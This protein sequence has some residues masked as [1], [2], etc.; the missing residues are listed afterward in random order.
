MLPVGSTSSAN[1]KSALLG[2]LDTQDVMID[3]KRDHSQTYG[4]ILTYSQGSLV[5]Y[6]GAYPSLS[7]EEI[8]LANYREAT[9]ILQSIR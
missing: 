3:M 8:A 1:T 2:S 5:K 9:L 7:L 6:T 4:A